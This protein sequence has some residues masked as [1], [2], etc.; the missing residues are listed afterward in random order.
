MEADVPPS[1]VYS[2]QDLDESELHPIADGLAVIYTAKD[3]GKESANQDAAAIL[4]FGSRSGVLV[5]ADGAGG[6]PAGARASEVAVSSIEGSLRQAAKDDDDLRGAIINGIE[7]ANQELAERGTGAATTLAAVEIQDSTVR[8]YHVG[9]SQIMVFGQRGK[10][11]LL[12][13][14]HSPVGYAVEAGV[15]DEEEAMHHDQRHLISNAIGSG[16]MYIE[17][18]SALEMAPRDTVVVASDGLFDNLHTDEIVEIC[19]KGRLLDTSRELIAKCRARMSE[20][21]EGKP[22]K[23][24]D[25]S[26]ILYRR[27]SEPK[28]D[29]T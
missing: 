10:V 28:R 25:L 2:E 5:I 22:S 19:R 15:L 11:K 24:D 29:K 16:E 9:D 3:P 27:E 12:T 14:S 20:P 17:I 4:P 6:L 26:F 18:G 23:P 13:K 21:E 8:P 7:N 1:R